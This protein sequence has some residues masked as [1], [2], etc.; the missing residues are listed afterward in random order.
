MKKCRL[1]THI[2]YQKQDFYNVFEYSKFQ[3]IDCLTRQTVAPGEL[4]KHS[5]VKGLGDSRQ[6]VNADPIKGSGKKPA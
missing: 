5:Q 4:G 1:I 3:L 6:L 2:F